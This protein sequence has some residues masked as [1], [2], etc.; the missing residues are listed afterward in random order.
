M[1]AAGL[2]HGGFY[3][4]FDSRDDLVTQAVACAL[5]TG[6][7]AFECELGEKGA[8]N[9]GAYIETY[10]S[11]AHRDN[12][13]AG[14]ALTALAGDVARSGTATRDVY[15]DHVA[16]MAKRVSGLMPAELPDRERRANALMLVTSMAGALSVARAIGD[17]RLSSEI[18][19]TA[20]ARLVRDFAGKQ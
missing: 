13:A 18:L 17:P 15:G 9:L 1:K 7:D 4:H 2:T 11:E 8:L 5:R 20:R 6:G 16:R 14:C 3:R 10:L 19:E 12:P